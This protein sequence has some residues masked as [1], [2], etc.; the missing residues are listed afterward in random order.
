VG[1]LNERH[2]V[3]CATVK[4]TAGQVFADTAPLL[5]E[6]CTTLPLSWR[7]DFASLLFRKFFLLY[8]YS[9]KRSW[10]ARRGERKGVL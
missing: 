1:A 10:I 3:V 8:P 9:I 7:T 6:A 5:G 2:M 4:F